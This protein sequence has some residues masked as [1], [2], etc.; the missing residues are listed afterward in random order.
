[1]GY[2]EVGSLEEITRTVSLDEVITD[3]QYVVH[4]KQFDFIFL[5][6]SFEVEEYFIVVIEVGDLH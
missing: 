5:H 6:V 4:N 1:M 2:K 3:G